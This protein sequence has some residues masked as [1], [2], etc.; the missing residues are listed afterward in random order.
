MGNAGRAGGHGE[1]LQPLPL[2]TAAARGGK[3]GRTGH[4]DLLTPLLWGIA[5]RELVHMV[6][7]PGI[8]QQTPAQDQKFKS[9]G[10][11]WLVG[12]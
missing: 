4:V 8:L 6:P 9:P 12:P 7:I 11:S 2:A 10:L 5:I 3:A 1:Q